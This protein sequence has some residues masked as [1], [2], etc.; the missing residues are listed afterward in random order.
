VCEK[1]VECQPRFE[2]FHAHFRALR[3]SPRIPQVLT[4]RTLQVRGNGG[5]MPIILPR[6]RYCT[7]SCRPY[8]LFLPFLS[9][10]AGALARV[11]FKREGEQ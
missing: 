11:I 8:N 5:N 6:T 2:R 3:A 7:A 1:I 9:I 10:N 4:S